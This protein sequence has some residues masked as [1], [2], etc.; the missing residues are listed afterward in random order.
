MDD[1]LKRTFPA[2]EGGPGIEVTRPTDGQMFVLAL[3]R[4]GGSLAEQTR[5]V[6]RLMKVLEA[7]TGTEQWDRVIEVAVIDGS[8]SPMDLVTFAQSI[9]TF[10]WS[11]D[12][13]DET[14]EA[15]AE[16]RVQ[17]A[18]DSADSV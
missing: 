15:P 17:T 1:T 10:D 16:R 3:S 7:L 18:T 13:T 6:R 9:F 5:L 14:A 11:A 4:E 12:E 2:Y 8:M